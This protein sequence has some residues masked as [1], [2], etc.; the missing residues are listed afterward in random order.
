M[1]V[2]QL[3]K[4]I[5]ENCSQQLWLPL[6]V[7][8]DPILAKKRKI[9]PCEMWPS[10][11]PP[12]G[13]WPT[14]HVPACNCHRHPFSHPLLHSVSYKWV[15]LPQCQFL[16][17]KVVFQFPFPCFSWEIDESHCLFPILFCSSDA[18]CETLKTH[19]ALL[20]RCSHHITLPLKGKMSSPEFPSHPL[21]HK[22]GKT[23][24]NG[25]WHYNHVRSY[26]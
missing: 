12:Q 17:P 4:L 10:Q 25:P 2:S 8:F 26:I 9:S 6:G 21:S 1:N 20:L 19:T 14:V 7:K 22:D 11:N 23:N 24:E 13:E 5:K 16:L 3:P 15:D 18:L